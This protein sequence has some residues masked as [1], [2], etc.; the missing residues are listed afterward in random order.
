[1]HPVTSV[2]ISGFQLPFWKESLDLAL[3]AHQAFSP[4]H[5]LGW[6]VGITEQ[7]PILIEANSMYDIDLLQIA[8]DRGFRPDLDLIVA[9][10][11][12]KL[13]RLNLPDAAPPRRESRPAS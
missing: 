13:P 1:M 11:T 10:A 2:Q 6:D 4:L 12:E 7:G 8:F 3:R 5:T 9:A